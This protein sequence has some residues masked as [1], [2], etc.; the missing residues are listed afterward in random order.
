M[1]VVDLLFSI[2]AGG[3]GLGGLRTKEEELREGLRGRLRLPV[4][5]RLATCDCHAGHGHGLC[6]CGCRRGGEGETPQELKGGSRELNG[7]C[8]H[9]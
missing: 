4:R 8:H 1:R 9:Y 7:Q 6:G 5:V 2:R 3:V